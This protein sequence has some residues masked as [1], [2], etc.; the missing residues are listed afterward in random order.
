MDIAA[1]L[2]FIFCSL[3]LC[4]YKGINIVYPL[5]MGLILLMLVALRRGFP[6]KDVLYMALKGS[7]KS[8]LVIRVFILIGAITAAWRASGTVA[9]IV[10]YGIELMN[11]HFFLLSAFLLCVAVSFLLGASFG[12]IGTIGIVMIILAKSGSVNI[13]MAAGAIIAG[14][15]FGDRCSPMSSSALLVA[16]VTE[17]QL[18]KNIAGMFKTAAVPLVL[19]IGGYTLLSMRNPLIFQD[20]NIS[21]SI[22]KVFHIPAV[23]ILP[24]V[25]ILV[26]AAFRVDV[27]T[28][29]LASILTGMVLA[30]I[31]Q[32]YS[33]TNIL[34]YTLLG[35]DLEKNGFFYDIIKGG[36][37]SSMA[38]TALIVM[39]SSAYSG[40]FEGTRMLKEIQQVLDNIADRYGIFA[41]TIL[42][43]LITASLG[44][45]QFLAILLTH[46]LIAETYKKKGQDK[47]ELAQDLENTAVVLSPLV[48]WN[49][50]G[51]VPAATLSVT[52]GFIP[53][54]FYLYLIPLWNL[55]A[56]KWG[57]N[58]KSCA[59]HPL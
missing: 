41:A 48:P 11:P 15:Y 25:V 13:S 49:I 59:V 36:G 43:G 27:K 40:V 52:A 47:Y 31:L 17:T 38:K 32:G 10:Y 35:F 58:K 2:I 34:R 19:A 18:Y 50:A 9:F 53:Y 51:T 1:A 29:M 54:A 28:S 12:T 7:K 37:V 44:C 22:L 8:L 26:L 24:A 55:I 14:S 45:T 42:T 33:V 3:L 5:L 20:N 46:Q 39:I 6:L 4:V 30:F 16:T 56:K 57:R 21:Q 23:T